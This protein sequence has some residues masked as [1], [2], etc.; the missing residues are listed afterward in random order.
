M[1]AK[2]DDGDVL[3]TLTLYGDVVDQNAFVI[4]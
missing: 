2:V 3:V 4:P 1:V